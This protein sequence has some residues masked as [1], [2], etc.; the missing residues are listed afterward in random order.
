M[1]AFYLPISLTVALWKF[2]STT[3]PG[4]V[5]SDMPSI[6]IHYY[7][8][9]LLNAVLLSHYHHSPQRP[10]FAAFGWVG[11]GVTSL[12]HLI[13]LIW[14]H[15]LSHIWSH[16]SHLIFSHLSLSSLSLISSLSLLK[17]VSLLLCCW[18]VS[19]LI[20]TLRL[21]NLESFLL[22]VLASH[23][24]HGTA[25]WLAASF[26]VCRSRQYG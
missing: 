13:S 23:W 7:Y 16:L 18:V 1:I 26:V 24:W 14:S 15:F 12:S 21:S 20:L 22:Q 5:V 10:P 11:P 6:F 3:V 25:A 4:W 8:C 9:N 19:L 17:E 2:W